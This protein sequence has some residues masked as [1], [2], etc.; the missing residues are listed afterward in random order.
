ML[1]TQRSDD[2]LSPETS[3]ILPE[4][5]TV[6]EHLAASSENAQIVLTVNDNM[7]SQLPVSLYLAVDSARMTVGRSTTPARQSGT[8]YQMNLEIPTIL[9]TLNGS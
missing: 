5:H 3:Q 6:I 4:T 2:T 8:R 7:Q 1:I 9:I